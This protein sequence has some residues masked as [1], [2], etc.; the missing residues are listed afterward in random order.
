MALELPVILEVA[1]ERRY[2]DEPAAAKLA[3]EARR[4]GRPLE[5]L[6]AEKGGLSARRIERLLTHVKYRSLRKADKAYSKAGIK[7]GLIDQEQVKAALDLQ[8]R[9][10]EERRDCL[11]LGTILVK[12][13]HITAEQDKQIRAR[14]AKISQTTSGSASGHAPSLDDSASRGVA[15][16]EAGPTYD[17][18]DSAM[19]RVEAARRVQ[20]DLSESVKKPGD[21]KATGD[22]AEE[23]ENACVMLARRRVQGDR[24]RSSGTVRVGA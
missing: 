14:V 15:S 9:R 2:L 21:E 19:A 22:S 23:F 20:E 4:S 8:R 12:Q 13:G 16:V 11:R 5:A 6:L 10:F 7:A 17:A 24:G 3:S 1:V 18:I